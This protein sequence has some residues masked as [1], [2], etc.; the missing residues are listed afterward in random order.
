M[1]ER[2]GCL[3]VVGRIA[4]REV[5]G[6]EANGPGVVILD[7]VTGHELENS[8][9]P[10]KKLQYYRICGNSLWVFATAPVSPLNFAPLR[11]ASFRN[12]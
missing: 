11:I 12:G 7:G 8:S 10:V 6:A 1:L 4:G 5:H 3:S 9:Q 2:N